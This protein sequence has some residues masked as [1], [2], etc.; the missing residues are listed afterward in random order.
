MQVLVFLHEP[1]QTSTAGLLEIGVLCHGALEGSVDETQ[2]FVGVEGDQ[3]GEGEEED[4]P[5]STQRQHLVREN[6]HT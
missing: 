2:Q 5:Q 1:G 6:Q 4:V 3:G